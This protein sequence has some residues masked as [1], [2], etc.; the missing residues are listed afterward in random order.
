MCPL[1][2]C[3]VSRLLFVVYC[4]VVF[5]AACVMCLV[6][7]CCLWFVGHAFLPALNYVVIITCCRLVVCC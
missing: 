6:G 5:V 4:S 7:G 3:V 2:V 1:C